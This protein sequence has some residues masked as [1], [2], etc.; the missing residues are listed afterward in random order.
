MRSPFHL[1]THKPLF[2]D[3]KVG[4]LRSTWEACASGTRSFTL[5]QMV[6]PCPWKLPGPKKMVESHLG[7]RS[8]HALPD[9]HQHLPLQRLPSAAGSCT[10]GTST[11][12]PFRRTRLRDT[13]CESNGHKES[14]GCPRSSPSCSQSIWR[15][16]RPQRRALVEEVFAVL[17]SSLHKA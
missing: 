11:S 13:S 9:L 16:A 17:S 4:V 15:I 7:A 6:L 10:R 8:R 1:L 5:R 12:L 14:L 2:A 3:L